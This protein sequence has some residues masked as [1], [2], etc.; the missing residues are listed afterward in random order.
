MH[1]NS[2]G[3]LLGGSSRGAG[4][5]LEG[6]E[7]TQVASKVVLALARSRALLLHEAPI[8]GLQHTVLPKRFRVNKFVVGRNALSRPNHE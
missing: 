8:L 5:V 3:R 4:S 6:G 2:G 1:P 7:G